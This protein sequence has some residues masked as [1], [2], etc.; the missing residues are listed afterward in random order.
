[1]IVKLKF[2]YIFL[3]FLME[4]N[5]P[6]QF[7]IYL[8]GYFLLNIV[9]LSCDKNVN[10]LQNTDCSNISQEPFSSHFLFFMFLHI[11]VSAKSTLFYSSTQYCIELCYHHF[12]TMLFIFMIYF[13]LSKYIVNI[14]L[15]FYFSI[16]C[17]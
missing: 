8:F 3:L 2:L 15:Q 10:L 12:I 9:F 16:V 7:T 6:S 4:E 1:M 17:L 11:L 13:G 5:Y 14:F